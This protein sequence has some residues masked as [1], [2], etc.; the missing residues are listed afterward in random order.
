MRNT[1]SG[2]IMSDSPEGMSIYGTVKVGDRGQVVI[3][4]KARK[5]FD[6]KPGELLLVLAGRNR[7]GITMVKTDA[8]KEF[9][10]RVLKGLEKTADE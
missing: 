3:P 8:I 6:I 4:S 10:S 5:D 2:I 1:K 7:R 9:A